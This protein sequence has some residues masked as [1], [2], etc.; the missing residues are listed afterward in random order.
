MS[1]K[2]YKPAKK[3]VEFY[4][5][6]VEEFPAMWKTEDVCFSGS[7]RRYQSAEKLILTSVAVADIEV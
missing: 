7:G 6:M 3:R 2:E 4:T 1:P 5:K